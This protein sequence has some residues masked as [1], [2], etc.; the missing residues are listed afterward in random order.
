MLTEAVAVSRAAGVHA[1]LT[2]L[3]GDE[4]ERAA[5]LK[6]VPLDLA[7]VHTR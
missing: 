5:A 1:E 2:K 4:P 3:L 6:T 7:Y